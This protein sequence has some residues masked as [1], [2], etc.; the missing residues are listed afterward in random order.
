MECGHTFI[1]HLVAVRTISPSAKPNPDIYLPILGNR[2][3]KDQVSLNKTDGQAYCTAVEITAKDRKQANTPPRPK[4][5]N[6][7][8]PQQDPIL[9]ALHTP[10][11][12]S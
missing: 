1:C 10:T 2:K 12:S 6:F 4:V 8:L 9:Q 7:D 3:I 5:A 11:A